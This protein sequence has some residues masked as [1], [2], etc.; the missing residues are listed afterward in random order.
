MKKMMNWMLTA[1]LIC[2][3]SVFMTDRYILTGD[4]K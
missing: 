3:T 1:I 4:I 2:G